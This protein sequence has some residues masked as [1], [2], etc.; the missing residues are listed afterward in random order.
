MRA[1]SLIHE[2]QVP[3]NGLTAL[4]YYYLGEYYWALGDQGSNLAYSKKALDIS[5][6]DSHFSK[7]S[8]SRTVSGVAL[9]YLDLDQ[10]NRA[11]QYFRQ[12]IDLDQEIFGPDHPG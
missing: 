1:D 2:S 4:I 10:G 11:A 9:A 12:I 5:R 7:Y 3:D 6:G 8:V